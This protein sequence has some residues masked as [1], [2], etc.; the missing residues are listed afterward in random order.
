MQA[1][2]KV[3]EK[4]IFQQNADFVF[5]RSQFFYKHTDCCYS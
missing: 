5:K 1:A 4:I 2:Q 3:H